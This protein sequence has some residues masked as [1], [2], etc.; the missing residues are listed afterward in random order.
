MV[1][2]G[3]GEGVEERAGVING[4]REKRKRQNR[5]THTH[6]QNKWATI[7]HIPRLSKG[8]L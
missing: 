8:K 2:G 5:R 6:T 7:A 1:E 4:N 3:G